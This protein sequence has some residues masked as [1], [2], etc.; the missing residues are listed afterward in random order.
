MGF[1]KRHDA[2]IGVAQTS[3]R[4]R[5]LAASM[6][7]ARHPL[8]ENLYPILCE[9]REDVRAVL[10]RSTARTIVFFNIQAG[11]RG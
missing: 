1:M 3:T 4:I 5:L 7:N 2:L 10:S 6:R 11:S 9:P 8:C